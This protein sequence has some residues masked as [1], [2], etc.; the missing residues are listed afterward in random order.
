VFVDAVEALRTQLA[1]VTIADVAQREAR[2][3]G[4]QMYYI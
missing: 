3:A 2:E 1:A 4:A